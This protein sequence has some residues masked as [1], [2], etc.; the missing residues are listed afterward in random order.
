MEKTIWMNRT[1]S[2]HWKRPAVGIVRV[3]LEIA[4]Q[5]EILYPNG[6]YKECIWQY[7]RFI[8][9]PEK[10]KY[11]K[12]EQDLYL[13]KEIRNDSKGNQIVNNKTFFFDLLSR[14]QAIRN[15]AQSFFSLLPVAIRP[16]VNKILLFLRP[17][18]K[19]AFEFYI[20]IFRSQ[21]VINIQK[22]NSTIFNPGDIF[23]SLGLD[24][25]HEYFE[26]FHDMKEKYAIKL[27]T[28]CHDIIPVLYPQYCDPASTNFR[29][30]YISYFIELAHFS[31]Y[32]LCNSVKT[33]NDFNQ[34]LENNQARKVN[35]SVFSLGDNDLSSEMPI[36][37]QINDLLNKK[38]IIYVSTIE[39][40]KNHEILYRAY[41]RLCERGLKKELPI[42]IF[43][44]MQGWGVINLMKDI[45]FD[46]LTDGLI[47]ILNHVNDSELKKLYENALFSLYPSL[48]EGWG[49]PIAESL[50]LGKIVL[51]SNQ[52][53]IPEVAGDL[54][55]Y[56]DPWDVESWAN[57][58]YS[59]IIDDKKRHD[60]EK[61][62]REHYQRRTWQ[63]SGLEFK[64]VIDAYRTTSINTL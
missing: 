60:L 26:Y 16:I 53:S 24:M 39:R 56:L 9:L 45:E 3:E 40:R 22:E 13:S 43:V 1:T 34:F 47:I 50:S 17:V 46:P 36:S 5:L 55:I 35:T 42:L 6:I 7:D 29:A 33:Q 23:I 12:S 31:D 58:I 15:L 14:R 62:I 25:H 61:K 2:Y 4:S 49:L 8:E 10:S 20:K 11:K 18:Y 32:I 54:G 41:H 52:G 57:E 37:A 21:Q 19:L 48:Y 30:M 38:Y 64:K 59:L 28:F 63:Q 27:I 51:C 44:G